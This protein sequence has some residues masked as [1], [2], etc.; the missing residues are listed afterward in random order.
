MAGV[1]GVMMTRNR[2][3]VVYPEASL[4]FAVQEP[5]TI[6]TAR[7]PQ[8]FR[9]VGPEDYQGAPPVNAE[10][11]R[12]PA[13]GPYGYYAPYPYPYPYYYSP[14]PYYGFGFGVVI[15][16]ARAG[17]IASKGDYSWAG[18]AST[19]F[20]IDPVEDIS[21]VFMTQVMPSSALPIRGLLRQ[22]VNQAIVA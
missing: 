8:A 13:P 15:D 3:T 18:A 20:W 11:R 7:A 10:L 21:V 17:M 4:T 22:L 5:L 14:Y 9:Y 12:R 6:S 16:P 2:P 19:S 1:I